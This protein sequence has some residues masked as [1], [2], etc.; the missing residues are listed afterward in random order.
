ML[1]RFGDALGRQHDQ[2]RRVALFE[3]SAHRACSPVYDRHLVVGRALE[4]RN[5]LGER[6]RQRARGKYLDFNRERECGHCKEQRRCTQNPH[7]RR[8]ANAVASQ[9]CAHD[10]IPLTAS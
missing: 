9:L 8:P 4:L 6:L 2:I 1:V 7:E 10:T 3:H 5:Q